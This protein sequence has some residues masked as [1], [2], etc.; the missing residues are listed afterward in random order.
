[1]S[2]QSIKLPPTNIGG[3]VTN[4]TPVELSE[5]MPRNV[6]KLKSKSG[7]DL[8]A[9]FKDIAVKQYNE[10]FRTMVGTEY[11]TLGGGFTDFFIENLIAKLNAGLYVYYIQTDN[12]V[13]T[14]GTPIPKRRFNY[15]DNG[16]LAYNTRVKTTMAYYS[17]PDAFLEI[18]DIYPA[19]PPVSKGL[20]RRMK[21]KFS[22]GSNNGGKKSIKR[23]NI[24]G[25]T[26]KLRRRSSVR[27]KK[28]TRRK[29]N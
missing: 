12:L 7:V 1:M 17:I 18:L 24:R 20:F 10:N 15:Y 14:N 26:S 25:I 9:A 22:S 5:I 6:Y 4:E 3:Y 2:E 11:D 29:H 8:N 21:D 16:H 28:T 19:T 27:R 23:N 13:P